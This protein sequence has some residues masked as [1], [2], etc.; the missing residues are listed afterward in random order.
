MTEKSFNL[1][2]T[3]KEALVLDHGRF[4]GMIDLLNS[5][6][7][8]INTKMEKGEKVDQTTLIGVLA[9]HK[10]QATKMLNKTSRFLSTFA[11]DSKS[12]TKAPAKKAVADKK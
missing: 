4:K 7:K 10:M 8:S 12:E 9:A 1:K 11:D 3:K 5:V 6:E 2:L